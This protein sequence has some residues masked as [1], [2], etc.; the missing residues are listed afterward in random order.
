MAEQASTSSENQ[1]VW[2][3]IWRIRAPNK[4]RLFIWRAV[5]GSL[6]TKENLHKRHILLDVTCS[7]CDEHQEKIMH[8]LW[9]CDLAKAVWKSEVSFAVMYKTQFQAF[10]DLFETVL[11][12]GLVF[13]MAW[14]STIT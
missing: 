2:K 7:L 3:G 5:K 14:F 4:I 10:M 1:K 9:L 13:H 6:P 8:A 12:R 11:G